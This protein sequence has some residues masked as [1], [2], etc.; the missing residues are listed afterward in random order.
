[1]GPK[2][3][4]RDAVSTDAPLIARLHTTSWRSAYQGIFSAEYLAGEIEQERLSLWNARFKDWKDNQAVIVAEN[5]CHPVGFVCVFGSHSPQWGSLVDNLHVLPAAKGKGFGIALL[6]AAARWVTENHPGHG[7][8]L[9]CYEQNI[10]S[11]QFYERCGGKV[12]ET[13]LEA[14]PG[15]PHVN[16]LRF[17]WEQPK[18]LLL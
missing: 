1:M 14:V 11:R 8:Y 10:P 12:V 3:K 2:M 4:L 17:Y 9:W 7:F 6:K 15:G 13:K 5:D 18:I 16:A